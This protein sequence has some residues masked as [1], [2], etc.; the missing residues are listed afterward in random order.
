MALSNHPSGFLQGSIPF[1]TFSL[2]LFIT[3][4]TVTF[5]D[6]DAQQHFCKG[7]SPE[8]GRDRGKS[9]GGAKGPGA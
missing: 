8:A 5:P 1:F 9:S 6:S 7:A 2:R 4:R 3:V